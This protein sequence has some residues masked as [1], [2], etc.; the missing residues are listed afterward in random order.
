MGGMGL[1]QYKIV[2]N[3]MIILL[4]T[5]IYRP[6]IHLAILFV[7]VTRNFKTNVQF[8]SR[9]IYFKIFKKKKLSK[10]PYIFPERIVYYKR[11][12]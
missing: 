4:F 12:V 7:N 8:T 2:F 3:V 9:I 5:N 1:K 6:I 11:V 10:S